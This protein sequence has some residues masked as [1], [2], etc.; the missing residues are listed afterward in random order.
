MYIYII[1]SLQRVLIHL[2]CRLRC[3]CEERIAGLQ[4]VG[5]D[6]IR[7][8]EP[9]S[10]DIIQWE[11][12]KCSAYLIPNMGAWIANKNIEKICWLDHHHWTLLDFGSVARLFAIPF[13]K[14][15]KKLSK[16]DIK[17]KVARCDKR[18]PFQP[19]PRVMQPRSMKDKQ[20]MWC[21]AGLKHLGAPLALW[22]CEFRKY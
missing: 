18:M 22:Q 1:W 8:Q 11:F 3:Q 2:R 16:K 5:S 19:S 4:H 9:S 13:P 10:M 14:M 12:S 17:K 6:F 21:L 15:V 20:Q 7:V